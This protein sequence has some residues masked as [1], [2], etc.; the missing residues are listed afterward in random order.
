MANIILTNICNQKCP[1]CFAKKEMSVG[2]RRG[3]KE[4]SFENFKTVLE[5]FKKN[6]EKEIRL[7][8]GEPSLHSRFKKIVDYAINKTFCVRLFSNATFDENLIRFLLGKGN[9][10][11]YVLN[12]NEP[13]FYSKETWC[14][15]INNISLLS[16]RSNVLLVL[17]IYKIRFKY[18]Y[19]ARLVQR[20]GA[21]GIQVAIANPVGRNSHIQKSDYA[22]T[23]KRIIKMAEYFTKHKMKFYFSCG[24]DKNMFSKKQREFL[25]NLTPSLKWGC[26]ANKGL[27]DILP[28]LSVVRCFPLGHQK[29]ASLKKF[30]ST[31]EIINYFKGNDHKFIE[32]IKNG[33]CLGHFNLPKY[34]NSFKI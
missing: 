22:K 25:K 23:A 17:N 27:F 2:A 21:D 19:L 33:P 6:E 1:Y 3:K 30:A 18:K 32:Y 28:D 14:R 5:F 4:M 11:S 10:I 20:Y 34:N 13:V 7:L 12:I 24:F 16:N 8:G 31:G 15:I 29:R 9:K 26:Q